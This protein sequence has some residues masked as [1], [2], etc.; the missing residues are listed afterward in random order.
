MLKK[1]EVHH[2]TGVI[3]M[4]SGIKEQ[5]AHHVIEEVQG[6]HE[7]GEIVTT[8]DCVNDMIRDGLYEA[9]VEKVIAEASSIEKVMPATSKKAS[10]PKNTHYVIHGE[11]TSGV[12][13]YCKICRNYAPDTGEFTCWTLTSFC[14]K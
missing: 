3:S 7:R 9:D 5:L 10:S 12:K 6:A 1:K 2:G 14:I 4:N 13:V 11:S 8:D